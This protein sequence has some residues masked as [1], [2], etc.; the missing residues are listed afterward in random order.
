VTHEYTLLLGGTVLPGGGAPA[1]GALAWAEGTVLALGSDAEVRA[2]SRGD[3]AVLLA[4]DAFVVPLNELLEVGMPADLAVLD[5]DPR[6]GPPGTPRAV[7]R[8]GHVTEGRLP[9][10][11]LSAWGPDRLPVAR[12]PHP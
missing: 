9:G 8:G 1:C 4:T 11:S 5:A 6:A 7:I 12:A 10:G 3:S 2:I